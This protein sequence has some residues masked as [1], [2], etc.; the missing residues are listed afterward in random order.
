MPQCIDGAGNVVA[1][2]VDGDMI[3]V[4]P[5]TGPAERLDLA[6]FLAQYQVPRARQ[7]SVTPA[8]GPRIAALGPLAPA[9]FLA[10]ASDDGTIVYVPYWRHP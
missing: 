9:G 10:L 2:D 4:T 5:Q 7:A 8:Q 1:Y 3:V 6:A